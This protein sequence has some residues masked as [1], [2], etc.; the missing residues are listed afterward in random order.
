MG[1]CVTLSEFVFV[2]VKRKVCVWLSLGL[3]SISWNLNEAVTFQVMHR[4]F[5][6]VS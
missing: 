6:N 4:V 2:F 3:L 5:D 1:Y